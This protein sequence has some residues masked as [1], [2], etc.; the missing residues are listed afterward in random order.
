MPMTILQREADGRAPS[1][2]RLAAGQNPTI[3]LRHAT[4]SGKAANRQSTPSSGLQPQ[5]IGQRPAA[6]QQAAPIGQQPAGRCE[7]ASL[8][9][10]SSTGELSV[11]EQPGSDQ[12]LTIGQRTAT[13]GKQRAS[14]CRGPQLQAAD[15]QQLESFI[16]LLSVVM[17]SLLSVR[18]EM[19][20]Y[21]QFTH[22]LNRH[23]PHLIKYNQF[24]PLRYFCK[25]LSI[26]VRPYVPHRNKGKNDDPQPYIKLIT[27]RIL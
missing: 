13:S 21:I 23:H 5:V 16:K 17:K 9:R 6:C 25:V 4:N 22:S 18:L 19:N 26:T 10:L 3:D 2:L 20:I 27:C 15:C 14:I 7:G 8:Q 12:R 11:I 1:V 24:V